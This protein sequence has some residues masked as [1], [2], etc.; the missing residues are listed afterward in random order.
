V[1]PADTEQTGRRLPMKRIV[2]A[3]VT[4]VGI[5]VAG[6]LATVASAAS[7][8]H[9]AYYEVW[10]ITPEQPE[11][12]PVQAETVDAHAVQYEK[13]PGGKDGAVQNFVENHPGWDCW[14]EGP[15][16]A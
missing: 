5:T 15:F 14:L 6:P 4:V 7:Q 2:I 16:T 8:R 9:D 13:D 10:C 3:L 11:G 12:P 1:E